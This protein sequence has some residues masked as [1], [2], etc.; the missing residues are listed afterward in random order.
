MV[1][2]AKGQQKKWHDLARHH[3]AYTAS[4]ILNIVVASV[5]WFVLHKE[6]MN[7]FVG[8]QK[9]HMYTVHI[10]PG[11]ACLINTCIT[12]TVLY[13]NFLKPLQTLAVGFCALDCSMTF[14]IGAPFFFLPWNDIYSP[15]IC[16]VFIVVF[17]GT[18]ILL[19]FV[20]EKFK[21]LP[22]H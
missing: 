6:A 12:N 14:L 20:D 10:V 9:F 18:Y 5:Y 8:F 7:Y 11:V 1:D 19:C 21:K 4:I 13:R 3:F 15:L 16:L 17:S 2:N 22:R